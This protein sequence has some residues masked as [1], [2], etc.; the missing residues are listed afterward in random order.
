MYQDAVQQPSQQSQ[1]SGDLSRHLHLRG[2]MQ[3]DRAS[4][5]GEH[6]PSQR[7]NNRQV[8]TS[9]SWSDLSCAAVGWPELRWPALFGLYTQLRVSLASSTSVK[10]R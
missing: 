1:G 7:S 6:S 5:A 9:E 2:R 3:A 8:V 4:S 10:L